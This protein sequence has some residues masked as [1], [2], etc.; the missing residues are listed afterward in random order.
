MPA[1][2][3]IASDPAAHTSI[4]FDLLDISAPSLRHDVNALAAPNQVATNATPNPA[5]TACGK[6]AVASAD[7]L[8]IARTP[9]ITAYGT[10]TASAT[11]VTCF[12]P[13]MSLPRTTDRPA[14]Q[15]IAPGSRTS[16]S[17]S[18]PILP[19][20]L[21]WTATW[22]PTSQSTE[23]VRATPISPSLGCGAAI[24]PMTTRI[25]IAARP[26]AAAVQAARAPANDSDSARRLPPGSLPSA[27]A[28][29]A[30]G[31]TRSAEVVTRLHTDNSDPMSGGGAPYSAYPARLGRAARGA[32]GLAA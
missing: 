1:A 13:V 32:P 16:P 12:G 25:V 24:H 4:D 10:A 26:A 2:P 7:L 27:S 21:T 15:S 18:I 23:A 20:P 6:D 31:R 11:D 14:Y 30:A 29:R 5:T 8:K 3:S 19:A 9:A 17:G 28:R 22:C